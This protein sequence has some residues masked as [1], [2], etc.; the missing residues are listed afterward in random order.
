MKASKRLILIVCLTLL[1]ILIGWQA[2]LAQIPINEKYFKETGH[3]VR[4]E[5]LAKYNSVSNP[6]TLFGYPVSAAFTSPKSGL[7]VQYFQ[8]V[9]F[10]MRQDAA[11]NPVVQISNL[12]ELFN[13]P[14]DSKPVIENSA[15]CRTFIETGFQAC[16]AFLNFFQAN[17]GAAQFGYPISNRQQLADGQQ[18]QYFQKT[19]L[20]YRPGLP[21]GQRIFVAE[22]GLPA[23]YKIAEDPKMLAAEDSN[24]N[25]NN[26]KDIIQ[27]KVRAYPLKAVGLRNGTQ[28]IYVIVQDQRL[29]PVTGATVEL[30]LTT[31]SGD[32]RAI[33]PTTVT[34]PNGVAQSTF[35][36][37]TQSLGIATVEVLVRLGNDLVGRTVT[38]FRI[39]W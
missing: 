20:E 6:V 19:R 13:Q 4:D 10:E 2:G 29:L 9:R 26:I 25:I 21:A 8:K 1:P 24:S 30:T 38:S 14:A 36:Y 15:A 3:W 5:F 32:P 28:T 37:T 12:G 23:F 27:L 7:K 22:L 16:Y 11:G 35:T 34:G 17:G 33:Q 39:W 18:I 31:P